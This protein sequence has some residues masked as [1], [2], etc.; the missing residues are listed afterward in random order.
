MAWRL[1]AH[2]IGVIS[3]CRRQDPQGFSIVELM[4]SVVIFSILAAVLV[5]G[6][7]GILNRQDVKGTAEKV[8]EVFVFA[9]AQAAVHTVAHRV[10]LTPASGASG[11][12]LIVTQGTETS[13]SFAATDTQALELRLVS[14][15]LKDVTGTDGT[16]PGLQQIGTPSRITEITPPE[17]LQ[18]GLCFRPD[19]SVRDANTNLPVTSNPGVSSYG[20]GDVMIAVQDHIVSGAGSTNFIPSGT[21]LRVLVPYSGVARVTY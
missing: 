1:L 15:A 4:I 5:P 19:G 13:C 16:T 3:M 18:L 14:V 9:K 12:T 17:I 20:A 7:S 8:R 21:P 11:G 2:G 10:M 6:V